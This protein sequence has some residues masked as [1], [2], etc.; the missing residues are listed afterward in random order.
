MKKLIQSKFK[1][2]EYVY[3]NHVAT[4]D[5][6]IAL[7]DVLEPAYWGNVASTIKVGDTIEVMP[8]GL[9]YYA[10]LIVID[11]GPV[12]AKVKLLQ[13][14]DLIAEDARPEQ[15]EIRTEAQ[16]GKFI[17]QR[18]GAWFRVIREEDKEVMKTGFR[19]MAQAEQ[20]IADNLQT[21][22]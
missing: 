12:Y 8:E 9:T 3:T 4:P 2:A 18:A 22:A 10:R 19:T 15:T 6:G 14:V 17:A 5:Y 7:K 11:A 16:Y 13:F 1:R 20:W 21:E